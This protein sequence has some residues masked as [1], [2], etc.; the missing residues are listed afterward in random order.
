MWWENMSVLEL[1]PVPVTL[2]G[3]NS[4]TST[5]RVDFRKV[6]DSHL[7]AFCMS[8]DESDLKPFYKQRNLGTYLT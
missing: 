6:S 2:H 4:T 8:C 1:E 7:R 5:V 3:W